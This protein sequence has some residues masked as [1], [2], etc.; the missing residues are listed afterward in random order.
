VRL[1]KLVEILFSEW[2]GWNY[3]KVLNWMPFMGFWIFARISG[4]FLKLFKSFPSCLNRKDFLGFRELSWKFSPNFFFES[5]C[6]LLFL[7][8]FFQSSWELFLELS[9]QTFQSFS[10]QFLFTQ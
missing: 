7:Q 10:W 9:I 1:G 4:S 3:V 8:A 2:D 5:F 6:H